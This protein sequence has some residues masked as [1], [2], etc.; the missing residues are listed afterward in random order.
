M[1]TT[2]NLSP[3]HLL[4]FPAGVSEG[5]GAD[6]PDHPDRVTGQF[7]EQ[8]E[9]FSRPGDQGLRWG[10]LVLFLLSSCL[11]SLPP[12]LSLSLSLFLSELNLDLLCQPVVLD[13]NLN[14]TLS[15]AKG[16]QASPP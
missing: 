13:S 15:E 8:R 7:H 5:W 3:S 9:L 11:F 6:G 10:P 4:R 14:G 1:P 12:S 16:L 2:Q